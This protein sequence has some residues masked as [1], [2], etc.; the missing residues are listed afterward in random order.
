MPKA[1][2]KANAKAKAKTKAKTET[3]KYKPINFYEL[4][5]IKNKMVEVRNPNF[6]KHGIKQY[7]N[8]LIIGSTGAGKTNI[9]AN[10]IHIMADTFNHIFIFT[11]KNRTNL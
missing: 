7:F 4:P 10:L 6:H 2:V 11:K 3:T 9:L 5:A 1:N 8:M